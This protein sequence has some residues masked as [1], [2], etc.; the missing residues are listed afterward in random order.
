MILQAKQRL[1]ASSHDLNET[2][3]TMTPK[4]VEYVLDGIDDIYGWYHGDFMHR[5]ATGELL[6]SKAPTQIDLTL[7]ANTMKWL[8][9]FFW[10]ETIKGIKQVYRIHDLFRESPNVGDKVTIHPFKPMLSWTTLPTPRVDRDREDTDVILS[11][12]NPKVLCAE[13]TFE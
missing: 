12:N 9:T 8:S 3:S 4:Q 11:L 13:G 10:P 6:I 1:T 5:S 7:V 2:L